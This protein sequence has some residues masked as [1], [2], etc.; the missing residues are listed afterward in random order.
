MG[1]ALKAA[2]PRFLVL[3]IDLY[4][5]F[6]GVKPVKDLTQPRHSS[7]TGHLYYKEK[8]LEINKRKE[9]EGKTACIHSLYSCRLASCSYTKSCLV[10]LFSLT[11]LM[12]FC[13]CCW[14]FF[15]WILVN[16]SPWYEAIRF[17]W[18]YLSGNS[19]LVAKRNYICLVSYF[20]P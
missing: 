7:T 20:S 14:F 8:E 15:V 16:F 4:D 10:V 6:S 2:V 19:N 12:Y 13:Y 9:K 18:E 1:L 5:L 3:L 17:F 11:S